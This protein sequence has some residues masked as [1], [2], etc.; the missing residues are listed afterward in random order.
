MDWGA[1]LVRM[2]EVVSQPNKKFWVELAQKPSTKDYARRFFLPFA[3]ICSV[4]VCLPYLRHGLIPGI[5]VGVLTGGVLCVL[6]YAMYK[7]ADAYAPGMGGVGYGAQVVHLW[8]FLQ[9]PVG[10]GLMLGAITEPFADLQVLSVVGFAYAVYLSTL[11]LAE[12]Y[13]IPDE[14]R[15]LFLGLIGFTWLLVLSTGMSFVHWVTER[16][17]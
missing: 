5:L 7:S 4:F 17:W 14:R 8:G 9:I 3:L 16:M 15:R 13:R 10:L 2:V 1:V 6:P 11:F 12:L